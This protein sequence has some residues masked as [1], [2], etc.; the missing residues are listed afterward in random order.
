MTA[1]TMSQANRRGQ[2]AVHPCL[3]SWLPAFVAICLSIAP[4][5]P[6]EASP[7]AVLNLPATYTGVLPCADC[8]GV[9][10]TLTLRSDGLY[11]LRRTYLSKPGLPQ[12]EVGRWTA[13]ADGRRI[14][15]GSGETATNFAIKDAQT[16]RT[17]DRFGS[18][19]ATAANLDLRRTAQVDPITEPLRWHGE[20]HYMADAA[21]YTDCASG[22]RWPVAMAADYL[23]LERSYLQR[24]SAPGAPLLVSFDGRLEVRRAIEGAAREHIVVDRFVDAEP[25]VSCA[26][27]DSA[28]QSVMAELQDKRWKL[29]ELNGQA[30]PAAEA[31]KRE[32]S[33]TLASARN[34]L[35]GFSGC[36]RVVGV[37]ELAGNRLRFRQMA[38]TRMACAASAMELERRV[39]AMLAA[40]TGYTIAEGRLT[41]LAGDRPLARLD[42]AAPL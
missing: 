42:A 10:H 27:N 38:S 4:A 2:Q 12:S 1:T 36:N 3:V 35:S 7:G 5:A 40:T 19:I 29:V 11:R 34:Q 41:L 23:S 28:R 39:L 30:V 6:M 24:R 14:R 33:V 21:T 32:V 20:V 26:G 31:G 17:L 9:V 15:L 16:L 25:G 37:Y 18:A 22:L 13:D 8:P